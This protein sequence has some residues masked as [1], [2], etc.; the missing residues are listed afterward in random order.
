[1]DVISLIPDAIRFAKERDFE[2]AVKLLV[3][4]W[5]QIKKEEEPSW[6][7]MKWMAGERIAQYQSAI[8]FLSDSMTVTNPDTRNFLRHEALKTFIV[9]SEDTS[10]PFRQ[11]RAKASVVMCYRI[12]GENGL[13]HKWGQETIEFAANLER[14]VR[15][16]LSKASPP[17]EGFTDRYWRNRERRSEWAT[18]AL[19]EVD[20]IMLFPSAAKAISDGHKESVRDAL[21]AQLNETTVTIKALKE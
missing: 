7:V 9:I 15:R 2:S 8:R 20:F 16:K 18:W 1:M 6:V 19:L 3:Q 5:K 11:L 12:L 13:A 10:D 4:I 17:A 14:E 21:R